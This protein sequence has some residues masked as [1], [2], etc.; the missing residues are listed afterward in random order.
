MPQWGGG[1]KSRLDIDSTNSNAF[2]KNFVRCAL[3]GLVRH[4]AFS[5]QSKNSYC[6]NDKSPIWALEVIPPPPS[7]IFIPYNQRSRSVCTYSTPYHNMCMSLEA[8]EFCPQHYG[9]P[10]PS[11]KKHQCRKNSRKSIDYQV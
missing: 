3:Y 10:V 4:P 2:K 9:S 5:L 6:S 1:F 11:H 8:I 7:P